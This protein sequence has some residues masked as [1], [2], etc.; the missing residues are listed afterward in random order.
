MALQSLDWFNEM[1]FDSPFTNCQANILSISKTNKLL[2]VYKFQY[3]KWLLIMDANDYMHG[4]QLEY[5]F[6]SLQAEKIGAKYYRYWKGIKKTAFLP[7]AC[8]TYVL[9]NAIIAHCSRLPSPAHSVIH[10]CHISRFVATACIHTVMRWFEWKRVWFCHSTNCC[11]SIFNFE[12]I[13]F[14][15][16]IFSLLKSDLK[17]YWN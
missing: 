4:T 11:V 17:G 2:H 16:E 9:H 12:Q 1:L 3:Y 7:L 8:N 15:I 6:N 13:H 14:S 5:A 10:R